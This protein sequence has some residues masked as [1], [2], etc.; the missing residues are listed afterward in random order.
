MDGQDHN[1]FRPPRTD[2]DG[3]CGEAR[4]AGGLNAPRV[5]PMTALRDIHT[6][7]LGLIMGA[8]ATAA[9]AI[10]LRTYRRDR[11]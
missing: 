9:A 8:G 6:A 2:Y 10:A 5:A 1:V 11:A 3:A 7:T 4:M